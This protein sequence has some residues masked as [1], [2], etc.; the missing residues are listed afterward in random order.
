M[1]DKEKLIEVCHKVY[2]HGFVSAYDGNVSF[3]IEDNKYLITRSGVCQ[4]EVTPD[5]ILEIDSKGKILT[6]R[7]KV[8]TEL[9]LH[10]YI[11]SKRPEIKSVLHCHPVYASA[12]A[13]TG[14]GLTQNVF[15]EVILTL[16]KVPLCKYGTPSTE[17]LPFSLEPYIARSFAFLL[18]NHGAVTIG[19][20]LD[21]VY[22]KMEKL[23]HASKIIHTASLLG[24]IHELPDDE[25]R[26]LLSISE[27]TYG[28]VQD[29]RNVF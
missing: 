17:E 15:P 22:Y 8:T 19:K 21:D 1:S 18:E 28:I 4:G 24:K 6:G 10:F 3:K 12:F 9:K 25:V 7:G 13:I 16:G 14:K 26:K 23:E 5:D 29:E 20:S 27:K 11:Y 2:A